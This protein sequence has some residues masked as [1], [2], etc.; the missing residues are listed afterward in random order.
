MIYKSLSQ[1]QQQCLL[2]LSPPPPL[3]L[4]RTLRRCVAVTRS[5]PQRAHTAQSACFPRH[6]LL[7]RALSDHIHRVLSGTTIHCFGSA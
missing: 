1:Q 6:L 7:Q 4:L 3:Q 2:L 5:R